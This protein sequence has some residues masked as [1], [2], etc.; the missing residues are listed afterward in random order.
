MSCYALQ[1]SVEV[2]LSES[3]FFVAKP[4]HALFRKAEGRTPCSVFVCSASRVVTSS[5][6][7]QYLLD[8]SIAEYDREHWPGFCFYPSLPL[9]LNAPLGLPIF[10]T[11][12]SRSFPALLWLK[13]GCAALTTH[14]TNGK[15]V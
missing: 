6:A 1:V 4:K 13:R 9:Q 8:S 3:G 14:L 10:F 5:P 15:V 11:V 7:V 2:F 12:V